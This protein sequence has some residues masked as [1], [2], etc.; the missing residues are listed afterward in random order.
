[1]LF[2]LKNLSKKS[3]GDIGESYAEKYLKRKRYKILER[4]FKNKL[5]EIDIICS[6]DNSLCFVEVKSRSNLNF[7]SPVDAVNYHKQK[8]IINGAKYYIMKKKISR[9]NIRFDV[10][11]VFMSK[12]HKPVSLN[13]IE[14]AFWER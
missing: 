5:G 4:N 3:I 10:I 8:R 11:E 14:N 13:H 2:G 6:K 7:G 12:E 1:M 9:M